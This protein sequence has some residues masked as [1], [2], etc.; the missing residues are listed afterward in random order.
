MPLH[1]DEQ[2]DVNPELESVV[3]QESH[4]TTLGLLQEP[5]VSHDFSLGWNQS[6]ILLCV[7][8][9]LFG[10]R[11]E[12]K[13][14]ASKEEEEE[15]DLDCQR[16]IH[17]NRTEK[18]VA[19]MR[20]A[21]KKAIAAIREEYEKEITAMRDE[22]QKSITAERDEPE[23][24]IAAERDER[25]NCMD[26]IEEWIYTRDTH[27]LENIRL[28]TQLSRGQAVLVQIPELVSLD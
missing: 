21:R 5:G 26:D 8:V 9:N 14:K 15:I 24:A 7:P 13:G 19:A 6:M 1:Y 22:L 11:P 23:K 20:E 16:L 2:F 28:R 10:S 27:F 3:A 17:A 12:L 18:V 4:N 25:E